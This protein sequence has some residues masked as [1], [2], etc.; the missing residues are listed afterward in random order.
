MKNELSLQQA[1]P[2]DNPAM[3][4][5][6]LRQEGIHQLERLAGSAWTDFNEHD[7][8]I[9]ILEQYCYALTEL[10]YR[11]DFPL[12]DL[13]SREGRD[14]FASLF[15]PA[16]ILASR[17]VT[18]TDLRKLAIDVRGVKNAWIEKIG[19]PT[20]PVYYNRA[21]ASPLQDRQD[22]LIQLDKGEGIEPV[23]P[24]GLYRVLIEKTSDVDS[25][26][27]VRNVARRLHAHRPLCMDF[28]S[29]EVMYP[30]KIRV[31]ASIEIKPI[32]NPEDIFVAIMGKIDAHIAPSVPFYTLAQ[33]QAAGKRID[34]IFDGPMLNQ[35]F[36]DTVELLSMERKT[37]LRVS[38]FVSE[39][40]KVEGVLMVKYLALSIDGDHWEDWSL[41]LPKGKIP[42]TPVFDFDHL[43]INLERRQIK[44]ENLTGAIKRYQDAQANLTYRPAK[45]EDLDI[46]PP[47]ARDRRVDRY[48]SAQHQFPSVY[49]LGETGLPPQA[50]EQRRAQLKQLKAYLLFFD[51]LLANQFAQ[52]AHVGDLLGFGEE[53]PSDENNRQTYFAADINDPALGLDAVWQ[54]PDAK[55]RLARLHQIVEKPATPENEKVPQIDW[56]RKNRFLDH[57][58][59]RFAE[60]FTDYAQFQEN[61]KDKIGNAVDLDPS[62]LPLRHRSGQ[63]SPG[64]RGGSYDSVNL[65]ALEEPL[66]RLAAD[67]QSWLRRYPQLSADRGTAFNALMPWNGT[68]GPNL[69]HCSGLEQRLRIKLGLRPTI[70][71]ERF[72]LVEHVLL[73]PLDADNG[74]SKLLP[75]NTRTKVPLLADAR[76]ADPYSL[77]ISLVFPDAPKR[78]PEGGGFRRFVEQTL[79][80]EAPVHLL[81]HVRWL[82]GD[83]MAAFESAYQ[84]WLTYQRELR[85]GND[86]K[87]LNLPLISKNNKNSEDEIRL[88]IRLRD[89]RDRLIDLLGM[90]HTYPL[91]DL[92]VTYTGKVAFGKFGEIRL[93]SSQTGV[94]YELLDKK[95]NK[96]DPP[97]KKRGDGNDLSLSTPAITK[98][99]G[100]SIQATKSHNSLF[101]AKDL[102]LLLL[103]AIDIKI[104]LDTT[105]P[106]S[107]LDA[108][109]LD[110]AA[111]GPTD[112]RLVDY[113]AAPLVEVKNSQAGVYYDLVRIQADPAGADYVFKDPET[114]KSF[115]LKAIS[116]G[117]V[118]GDSHEIK[119]QPQPMEEDTDICVLAINTFEDSE[120]QELALLKDPLLLKV[121]ANPGL[122]VEVP[123]PLLDYRKGTKVLVKG[124]QASA[125]YQLFSR[126]MIDGIAALDSEFVRPYPP[127]NEFVLGKDPSALNIAGMATLR[128]KNPPNPTAD[129]TA[130]SGVKTGNGTDSDLA[131]AIGGLPEDS[132]VVVLAT[133]QH[134]TGDG[135]L[136]KPSSVQL[137]QAAAI[138]V[139]PAPAD[140]GFPLRLKVKDEGAPTEGGLHNGAAYEVLNGQPGV[141]YHFRLGGTDEDLGLPVYFHK[142]D[143]GIGKLQVEIDFTLT[144]SMPTPPPEWDCP[145]DLDAAAKL[146]I[147]AVKAQT[148]LETV[149]ER[150]VAELL[151]VNDDLGDSIPEPPLPEGEV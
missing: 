80:E 59:A 124:S 39:I 118:L 106:A 24:R 52:L 72:Y 8:G 96:L 102:T 85:E 48:Y 3:D 113:H 62:P 88:G 38:D 26:E 58:L 56:G 109:W 1:I 110:P 18:L 75:D 43:E 108:E 105:L 15:S 119:L 10:A 94:V 120:E 101:T 140:P 40:M 33:R 123:K 117:K 147:R 71:E 139:R 151:Q 121:R 141:F 4:Y 68:A 98:D 11:C 41:E 87:A 112:P 74:Q 31:K 6:S 95:G 99:T 37:A 25:P 82:A 66:E 65:T 130:L 134:K 42:V 127:D 126:P 92:P 149:F 79:R 76:C 30:Q 103:K 89:A 64:G 81:V 22:N 131:L 35:G 55:I 70:K 63:A 150:T 129:V 145:A 53:T 61:S 7:P 45:P 36:I 84:D 50:D 49:G 114:K 93:L 54:Q 90:G 146:S 14:P 19:Q 132:L 135:K 104:G 111:K 2:S 115:A 144:G 47:A 12:P 142:T 122:A 136:L 27:A 28:A 67:K 148:G 46:T 91:A 20:P 29:V 21:G 128:V 83:D 138:L 143:K 17:P 51:Q 60:Q 107:I 73:R 100:F 77:Q 133:K 78:F 23:N 116:T 44:V 9:T 69:D 57:L 137:T 13:L 16:R 125:S 34:E 86:E 97:V 32:D 5:F